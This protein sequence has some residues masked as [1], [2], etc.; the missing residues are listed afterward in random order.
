MKPGAPRDAGS[1]PRP[2]RAR[3]DGVSP[4]AAVPWIALLAVT[5]LPAR[6]WTVD[7]DGPADFRAIQDAI[8]AAAPGDLVSVAAGLYHENLVLKSGVAVVGAGADRTTLH[9]GGLGSTA[10]LI[11]CDAATRLE[12]FTLTGGAAESGGGILVI[13]GGPAITLNEIVGNAAAT[14]SA[15]LYGYGGGVAVLGSSARISDNLL[16]GNDADFGGGIHVD[17]GS[18]QITRNRITGNTAGAGGGIDTYAFFASSPL[19]ASNTIT[20]NTALFG[21]G[22]E[23]AGLGAPIVTNNLLIGN[24][25][26][27]SGS[28]TAYGGGA[29][30]YYSDA[31]LVNNTI[32]GNTARRGGG[33]ALLS[34]GAPALVNNV[35]LDNRATNAGGGADIQ[36]PGAIVSHNIFFLNSRGVCSGTSA[37]LCSA[38]TNLETDPLL[39]DAAGGDYRPGYGSPAIDSATDAVAPRDDQRGQRRPLDGD[40]DRVAAFDRGALEHDRDEVSGLRFASASMLI[41]NGAAGAGSY[42]VYSGMPGGPSGGIPDACRDPDDPDVSDTIF[43]ETIDPPSGGMLLYLVTAVIDGIER[44]PGFDHRGLERNLPLSCP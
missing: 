19:I 37:S 4:Y 1:R 44:S 41:W 5:L 21:G 30:V 36:A 6:T 24:S 15:Y 26:S 32:A 38:A 14:S 2:R 25:A 20:S 28:G 16:T 7:D 17:G 13:R 10:T 18:P 33:A 31:R 9:G 35:I 29:D 34:N 3:R 11:D 22:I 39:V 42:H 40:G 23:L 43:S 27:G 8:D 12:G